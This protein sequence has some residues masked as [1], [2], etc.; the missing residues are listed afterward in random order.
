MAKC[1]KAGS[2]GVCKDSLQ[3]PCPFSLIN[4]SAWSDQVFQ[5]EVW[6]IRSPGCVLTAV[7]VGNKHCVWSRYKLP[8][9]GLRAIADSHSKHG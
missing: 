1:A 7:A 4:T 6:R 9:A 5:F 2:W 8:L 3:I